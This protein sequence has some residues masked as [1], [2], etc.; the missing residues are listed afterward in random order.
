MIENNILAWNSALRGGGIALLSIP[1]KSIINNTLYGN[2]ASEFGG[3][4]FCLKSGAHHI[5]TNTIFWNNDAPNGPEI[6]I[7]YASSPS[8]LSISYCD[9]KG[10]QNSVYV[11]PGSTLIWGGG[12]I[13]DHPLFVQP[14]LDDFH[15]SYESPCRDAGLNEANFLPSTDFEGDPR[16]TF[17]TVDIGADEFHTHLYYKGNATP[18]GSIQLVFV[19]VPYTDPV[20]LVVGSGVI[21]PP[22]PT[23][24]GDFYLEFPL[25]LFDTTATLQH[26]GIYALTVDLPAT[27]PA[28]SDVPMQALIGSELTNLSVL[29]VR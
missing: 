14:V 18:G 11:H 6:S 22:I 8:T 12:M 23:V 3:G 10:G 26:Q 24:Y 19:G 29:K 13:D 16:I 28:P 15:V 25:I 9:V 7:G 27:V 1:T 20:I 17:G 5:V 2:I 4:L 21:D